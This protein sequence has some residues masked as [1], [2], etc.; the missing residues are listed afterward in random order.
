MDL[1]SQGSVS[2]EAQHLFQHGSQKEESLYINYRPPSLDAI[3]LPKHV[4][5]LLMAA[6][7]VIAV[8]YAIVGH[9]IKDLM[10]DFA[11]WAFGPK[12]EEQKGTGGLG[13]AIENQDMDEEAV[14]KVDEIS[15]FVGEESNRPYESNSKFTQSGSISPLLEANPTSHQTGHRATSLSRPPAEVR[16]SGV[17]GNQPDESGK[18]ALEDLWRTPT[19]SKHDELGKKFQTKQQ[20]SKQET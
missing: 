7:V 12:P 11:D 14:Q 6:F 1:D 16:S 17:A 9:L 19:V 15:V 8:A 5:Y 3:L 20:L 4:L 10:H 18:P 2:F 13:C